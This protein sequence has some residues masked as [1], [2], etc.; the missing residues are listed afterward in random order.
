MKSLI[1]NI[2]YNQISA[3]SI[4]TKNYT[5]IL[6]YNESSAGSYLT[7]LSLNE[8]INDFSDIVSI[9]K[10]NQIGN[11][12][13]SKKYNLPEEAVIMFYKNQTLIDLIPGIISKDEIKTIFK[14]LINNN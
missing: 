10:I 7:E 1:K 5:A 3:G 9:Y 2:T 4:L 14:N 12:E 8:I 6:F 11:E 13:L